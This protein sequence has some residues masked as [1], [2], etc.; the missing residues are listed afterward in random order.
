MEEKTE[1]LPRSF[2]ILRELWIEVKK[3]TEG[4]A[5]PSAKNS[6]HAPVL[7]KKGGDRRR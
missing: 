6:A 2:V 3:K 5:T 7:D 4:G 1:L